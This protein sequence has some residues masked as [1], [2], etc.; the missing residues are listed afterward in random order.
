M[1]GLASAA[2]LFFIACGLFL[3]V[4]VVVSTLGVGVF[5]MM[6]PR[7]SPELRHRVL[8]V[9]GCAPALLAFTLL[10]SSLL[11]SAFAWLSGT[12]DHCLVHAD[13]HLHLCFVHLPRLGKVIGGIAAI[14]SFIVVM[15]L[16]AATLA[17]LQL[18]R[19][20]RVFEALSTTSAKADGVN[21]VETEDAVCLTAG[22]WS[23][24]IY[25]SR[26][27]FETLSD[28]QRRIV[29]DHERAHVA[30]RDALAA[31][32][33]RSCSRLHWPAIRR[34]LLRELELA[35]E[36][37]CD[38]A[39]ALQ[40]DRL[41]VAE[42]ILL[43][44]RGAPAQ[45]FAVAFGDSA[46]ERRVQSMLQPRRSSRTGPFFTGVAALLSLVLLSAAGVH[47]AAE[48]VLSALIE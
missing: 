42:T 25:I 40:T 14:S 21:V 28:E 12:E 39:A 13:H 22:L 47:H 34:W 41:A 20:H 10:T 30:R 23:P 45:P 29:V 3:A 44:A 4:G 6:L 37:A 19:A 38:E 35:A 7:F 5:R 36:Q 1:N 11:P 9:L 48:S 8:L 17:L 31:L 27:L 18:R 15:E 32:V 24:A 16:A 46:L 43:V 2:T 33:A 26:R